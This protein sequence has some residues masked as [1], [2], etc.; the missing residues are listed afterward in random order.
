MTMRYLGK[1]VTDGG[2]RGSTSSLMKHLKTLLATAAKIQT[3][4]STVENQSENDRQ[5]EFHPKYIELAWDALEKGQQY[6]NS[7]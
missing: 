5:D 4:L 2:S 1:L 7:R 3:N 6:L